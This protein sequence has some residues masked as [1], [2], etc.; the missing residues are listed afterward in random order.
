MYDELDIDYVR[1]M[2]DIDIEELLADGNFLK[3]LMELG[4]HNWE[5]FAEAQE[6]FNSRQYKPY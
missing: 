3:C 4:V 2:K 5:G 1:R 6:M